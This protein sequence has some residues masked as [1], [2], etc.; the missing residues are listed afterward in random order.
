MIGITFERVRVDIR[1]VRLSSTEGMDE[2]Y[3]FF[4]S[5]L[6]CG[7]LIDF[8]GGGF[9]VDADEQLEEFD[10]DRETCVSPS[11]EHTS[12]YLFRLVFTDDDA[13]EISSFFFYR[14]ETR[15]GG[16]KETRA[17][18]RTVPRLIEVLTFILEEI[19]VER[20]TADEPLRYFVRLDSLF[21]SDGRTLPFG[22]GRSAT[23]MFDSQREMFI[24]M[25][26]SLDDPLR[27]TRPLDSEDL[28][29]DCF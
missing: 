21:D 28:P 18:Q 11:S 29:V 5:R 22:L 19:F 2:R 8:D 1:L 12:R 20:N 16:I 10:L 25:K 15:R 27:R 3:F 14:Q 26:I 7:L 13:G 9:N 23:R 24:S 4:S 17:E 6:I